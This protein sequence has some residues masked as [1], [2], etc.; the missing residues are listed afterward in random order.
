[1]NIYVIIINGGRL[2]FR[3]GL[4][5]LMCMPSMSTLVK[6]TRININANNANFEEEAIAA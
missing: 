5:N 4:Q 6:N 2:R 3:R 1:M